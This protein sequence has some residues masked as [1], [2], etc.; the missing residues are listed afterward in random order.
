MIWI[1]THLIQSL[2]KKIFMLKFVIATVIM[3][4]LMMSCKNQAS[5]AGAA[6][7][8]SEAAKPVEDG[9]HFGAMITP[10]GAISYDDMLVKMGTSDSLAIKIKGK[11]GAVCQKKG[12]WM[13]LLSDAPNAPVMTVNFK[14]YAF[15]M[16][17]DLTG[18]SV[19]LEGYAYQ[20]VTPVD[21]LRHYAED[22]G[23][24]KEEIAKITEPKKEL[25]Y[26]AS[27]VVILD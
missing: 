23:K 20:E 13:E 24:S 8:T 1:S 18:K 25:K 17:F 27:G 3:A 5:N 4:T 7:P 16:P 14:D 2:Y 26:E 6:A 12:C 9:K 10:D 15:F 11:V 21:E 22:A 19:A